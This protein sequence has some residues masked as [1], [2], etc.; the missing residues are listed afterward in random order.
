MKLNRRTFIGTTIATGAALA[1]PALAQAKP[2]L[3][4]AVVLT[5]RKPRWL[6]G[7]SRTSQQAP[8]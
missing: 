1:T 5:L 6:A 2:P 4:L 7:K 8:A 3:V